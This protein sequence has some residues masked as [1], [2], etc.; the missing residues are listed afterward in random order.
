MIHTFSAEHIDDVSSVLDCGYKKI[1]EVYRFILYSDNQQLKSVLE[2]NMGVEHEGEMVNLVSVY[3]HNVFLQLHNC[4][5]FVASETLQ[6]VTFFGKTGGQ[7]TGLI[8]EKNGS[9]NMYGN[10]DDRLLTGDFTKLPP[11]IMMGTIALSLT[12]SLDFEG[13]SFDD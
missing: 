1:G 5:G 8:I 6:Q 9:V 3:A 11:E 13:F 10:V 12:E 7:T 4:T 2:I